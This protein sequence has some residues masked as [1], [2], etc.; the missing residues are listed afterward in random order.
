MAS[1][2][3]CAI[4]KYFMSRGSVI[5]PWCNANALQ[6]GRASY[7]GSG[8]NYTGNPWWCYPLCSVDFKESHEDICLQR[9]QLKRP[10]FLPMLAVGS[11]QQTLSWLHHD[12]G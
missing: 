3:S 1:S 5:C 6:V 7:L 4:C 9:P 10:V 8:G 11:A 12:P 2:D